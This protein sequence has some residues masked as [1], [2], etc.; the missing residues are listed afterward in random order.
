MSR[1]D[2]AANL[3]RCNQ[4]WHAAI[5]AQ[6][7]NPDPTNPDAAVLMRCTRCGGEVQV[8]GARADRNPFLPR[9]PVHVV[10][11]DCGLEFDI[12]VPE[13]PPSG[14]GPWG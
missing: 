6:S 9:A 5:L 2:R 13:Q 1:R 12:D 11:S 10:C 3:A 7:D 4:S 8:R 14:T